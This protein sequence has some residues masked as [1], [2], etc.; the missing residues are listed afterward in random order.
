MNWNIDVFCEVINNLYPRTN[1]K[2]VAEFLDCPRLKVLNQ[3]SFLLLTNV[4]YRLA[5]FKF[6]IEIL[7][8]KWNNLRSQIGLILHAMHNPEV[9]DEKL[10]TNAYSNTE[11]VNTLIELSESDYYCEIR[12]FLVED[13]DRYSATMTPTLALIRPK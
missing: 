8:K 12:N 9:F 1:W 5:N 4:Y 2:L 10:T 11:L 7:F 13:L 6:P 3:N